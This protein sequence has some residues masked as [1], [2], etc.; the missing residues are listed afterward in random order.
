MN[1][2]EHAINQQVLEREIAIT[3]A[4]R[5]TAPLIRNG[6]I[7]VIVGWLLPIIPVLGIIGFPVSVISAF[8][9][10]VIAVSRGNSTGGIFL[11]LGGFFGT[12]LVWLFWILIYF[13]LGASLGAN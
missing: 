10:G 4:K 9:A 6:W 13:L 7:F 12:L 1:Q 2:Q 5:Q 8:T 3:A 11:I